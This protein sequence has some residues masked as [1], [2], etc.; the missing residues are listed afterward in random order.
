MEYELSTSTGI[1]M[2]FDEKDEEIQ[3]QGTAVRSQA[4][5]TYRHS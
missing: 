5:N 4:E 3:S 2:T 1:V